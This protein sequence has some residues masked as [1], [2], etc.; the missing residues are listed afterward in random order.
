M[1][2]DGMTVGESIDKDAAFLRSL[3]VD[4]KDGS[5]PYDQAKDEFRDR[6]RKSVLDAM[7]DMALEQTNNREN[8][9]KDS[10]L[11]ALLRAIDP[12]CDRIFNKSY[13]L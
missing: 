6:F 3:G 8:G 12:I 1:R 10:E 4:A 13:G 5:L 7:D 9:P 2:A 11:P